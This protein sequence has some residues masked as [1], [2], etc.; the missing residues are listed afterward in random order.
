[1]T[2]DSHDVTWSKNSNLKN[3]D[4][5]KYYF[6]LNKV[7]LF[8]IYFSLA[9]QRG[10]IWFNKTSG[11]KVITILKIYQK[12]MTSSPCF[13]KIADFSNKSTLALIF[14]YYKV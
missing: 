14:L 4:Q 9:I 1:M 13:W 6:Y 12:L 11:S 7:Y 5:P 8:E 2:P 3:A 10:V